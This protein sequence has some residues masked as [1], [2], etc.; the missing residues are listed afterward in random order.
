MEVKLSNPSYAQVQE[1]I[2]VIFHAS[3]LGRSDIIKNALSEIKNK[4]KEYTLKD[5]AEIVSTRR[6]EDDMTPLHIAS[7]H[8]HADVIRSLLV[9]IIIFTKYKSYYFTQYLLYT[10]PYIFLRYINLIIISL[11]LHIIECWS[12]SISKDRFR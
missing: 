10:L 12:R 6:V 8:G 11:L 5:T 7:V 3:A 1:E 2:L 9:R 4:C